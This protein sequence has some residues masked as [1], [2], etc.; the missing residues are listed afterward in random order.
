MV[1]KVFS[2]FPEL[3]QQIIKPEAGVMG[4]PQSGV[5]SD[6]SV[7]NLRTHCLRLVSEVGTVWWACAFNL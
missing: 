1:G 5:K 7:G 4:S 2:E 6:E 3:L